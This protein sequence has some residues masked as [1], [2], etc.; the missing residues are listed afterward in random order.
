MTVLKGC[1]PLELFKLYQRCD[2]LTSPLL[3]ASAKQKLSDLCYKF[4]NIRPFKC[5]NFKIACFEV[6]S[7]NKLKILLYS[8]LKTCPVSPDMLTLLQLKTKVIF[9]GHPKISQIFTN[10]IM[11]CKKWS[12]KPFACH[13]HKASLLLNIN[14]SKNNPHVSTLGHTTSSKFDRVLHSNMKNVA[15]PNIRSFPETFLASFCQYQHQVETFSDCLYESFTMPNL[16]SYEQIFKNKAFNQFY[17]IMS[18]FME[19]PKT[20]LNIIQE[21]DNFPNTFSSSTSLPTISEV[22]HTS[23]TLGQYLVLS[24]PDKNAG[25]PDIY[26]PALLWNDML[27]CFWNNNNFQI[28]PHHTP[29][30]SLSFF[31]FTYDHQGWASV[32]RYFT[33]GSL[34]YA[35]IM[36]KFKDLSRKRSIISYFHHPLKEV[37]FRAAAGLMTCLKAIDFFHTN[38]FNPLQAL[39]TMKL[40]YLQLHNKFRSETVYHSWAADVKEMYDWLPQQDIIKAIEWV[41]KHVERKSRRSHVTVF[42][43]ETKKNRL[44]KSYNSDTSITISF[45]LIFIISCFQLKHAY[46]QL[47]GKV[48]LQLLGLPQGGPGSPAFSMIVCIYYEFRFRCSIYDHLSFISFFRYFDDLR[49]VV[50]YKSSD[51]STKTLV[52]DLLHQLQHNTYHPSMK[53]VLEEASNNTFKFLE[54]QFSIIDGMLSCCWSSKNFESLLTTGQLKFITSQ[55]Y[56]SYAGNKKKIIRAATV[57]GRLAT[58][59]GYS[60]TDVDIISGFGYLI[61]ELFARY[62]S[63]KVF[64]YL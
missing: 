37:Y 17:S 36:R 52:A 53:L 56:F 49:A 60:F 14:L 6:L 27:N 44:G 41:L 10:H 26:C 23:K 32:G 42:Y 54:G 1:H 35:Y 3:R 64:T 25:I 55:D 51:I 48:F 8:F 59:L 62:Y 18:F 30:S 16:T 31:K 24:S 9:T 19:P 20:I 63:K 13:C 7:K 57:S 38:L 4:F 40:L 34:P 5:L 22:R 15:V 29:D 2:E 46:F 43:K 45:Q 11:W 58:L 47:N 39:P 21:F 12:L 61:T 50:V 28:Q 33:H